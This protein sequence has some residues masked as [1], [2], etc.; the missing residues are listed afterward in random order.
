[1]FIWW[2]LL[3]GNKVDDLFIYFDI[4]EYFNIEIVFCNFLNY[5]EL[6]VSRVIVYWIL[7]EV[8]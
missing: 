2:E 3:F 5:L 8:E 1:M 7:F 4:L 6:E